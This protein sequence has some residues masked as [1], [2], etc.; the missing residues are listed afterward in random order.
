MQT[1]VGDRRRQDRGNERAENG[2]PELAAAN[3]EHRHGGENAVE[4]IEAEVD[5][6][7]IDVAVIVGHDGADDGAD[8][9]DQAVAPVAEQ[10]AGEKQ[11]TRQIVGENKACPRLSSTAVR[12]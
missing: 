3:D 4:A 1:D 12:G 5:A 2:K 11:Q 10:H 7:G 8:E 6:S 9:G